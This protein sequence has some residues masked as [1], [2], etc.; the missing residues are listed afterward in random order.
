MSFFRKRRKNATFSSEKSLV[1]S[2]KYNG[3]VHV[4]IVDYLTAGLFYMGI[5]IFFIQI[6]T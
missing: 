2:Q 4:D 1:N 6:Y 3:L 5:Y